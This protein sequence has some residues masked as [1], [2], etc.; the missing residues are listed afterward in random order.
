VR[1]YVIS[2]TSWASELVRTTLYHSMKLTNDNVQPV[3]PLLIE[4]NAD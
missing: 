4:Y 1:W 2:P 3:G